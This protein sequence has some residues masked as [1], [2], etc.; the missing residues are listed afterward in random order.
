[1]GVQKSFNWTALNLQ[2]SNYLTGGSLNLVCQHFKLFFKYYLSSVAWKKELHGKATLNQVYLTFWRCR[3]NN[4]FKTKPIALL[5]EVIFLWLWLREHIAS[6]AKLFN[7]VAW[8]AVYLN[9]DGS[10]GET[11]PQSEPITPCATV[12][13]YLSGLGGTKGPEGN[14]PN[15]ACLVLPDMKTTRQL[16]WRGIS[17]NLRNYLCLSFA[18]LNAGTKILHIPPREALIRIIRLCI[19][20]N[21]LTCYISRANTNR[22]DPTCAAPET[23]PGTAPGNL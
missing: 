12:V 5:P 13:M 2:G 10:R 22:P 1:M 11:F 14:A 7:S 4:L 20:L 18:L 17:K 23:S 3:V 8:K 16:W 9:H 6:S 21:L 15:H 19:A